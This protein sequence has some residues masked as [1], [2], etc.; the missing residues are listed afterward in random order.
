MKKSILFLIFS[1]WFLYVKSQF[2]IQ[3]VLP[4]AGIIQKSNLWN[5]AIINTSTTTIECRLE[6]ILRNRINGLEVLTATTANIQLQAGAKQFNVSQ[7][8]PIQYNNVVNNINVRTDEL[9][10]IG[11]Y[12]ACYRLTGDKN[13]LAEECISFDIE[14]LSP[15]IL[16]TPVDASQLI[17]SPTQLTWLPPSPFNLFNRLSYEINIVE[18]LVGQKPVEAVQQNIPFYS[19]SNIPTNQLSLMGLGLPFEKE[20][21]YAW[22]VQARDDYNYAGKS[23]VFVFTIHEEKKENHL[24]NGYYLQIS[25]EQKGTYGIVGDTLHIKYFSNYTDYDA[26]ILFIDEKGN[27]IKSLQQKITQGDNYLD[28][29]LS[30]KFKANHIYSINIVDKNKQSHTLTFSTPSK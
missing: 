12:T 7:L 11:D 15:P 28:F 8:Q 4:L 25:D 29:S 17:N 20:K 10:P 14:P 27:T 16:I 6:L 23:D 9:L 26:T 2:T 24:V 19:A 18:L 21:T 3:P 13:I 22:Q 5:V 1:S 30:K